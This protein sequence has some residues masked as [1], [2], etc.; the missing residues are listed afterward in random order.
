MQL[1]YADCPHF[2][3]AMHR[4]EEI[5][6][7]DTTADLRL[8]KFFATYFASAGTRSLLAIPIGSGDALGAYLWIEHRETGSAGH[9]GYAFARAVAQMLAPRFVA[10]RV[11][12]PLSDDL[13]HAG[14]ATV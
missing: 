14:V 2:C 3:D 8:A 12:A 10:A 5:A 4:G 13:P 1:P 7:H 11:A 9:T 6:I